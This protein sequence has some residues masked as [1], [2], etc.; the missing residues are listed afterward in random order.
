[1]QLYIFLF[2]KQIPFYEEWCG[3][4]LKNFAILSNDIHV[5]IFK[6]RQGPTTWLFN[7]LNIYCSKAN[8]YEKKKD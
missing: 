4:L 6:E 2:R 7:D 8:E 3:T 1:M 5:Y